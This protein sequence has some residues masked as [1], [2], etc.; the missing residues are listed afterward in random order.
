L[1]DHQRQPNCARPPSKLISAANQLI[2]PTISR[3]RR[4]VL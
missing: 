1:F 2:T 4:V 3:P